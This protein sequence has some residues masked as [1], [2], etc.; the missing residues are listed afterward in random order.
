MGLSHK[1]YVINI[2]KAKTSLNMLM[3]LKIIDFEGLAIILD[4]LMCVDR[5]IGSSSNVVQYIVL[6]WA[7]LCSSVYTA[8]GSSSD[9]N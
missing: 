9:Y 5:N 7:D 6:Q 1:S 2:K 4:I 3:Q 8:Q